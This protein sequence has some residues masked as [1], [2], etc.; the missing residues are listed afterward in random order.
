MVQASWAFAK[1]AVSDQIGRFAGMLGLRVNPPPPTFEQI[2]SRHQ[3]MSKNAQI[4]SEN[5]SPQQPTS[6]SDGPKAIRPRATGDQPALKES[7]QQDIDISS[8]TSPGAELG[9]ELRSSFFRPILAFKKKFAQTWRPAAGYP[10]RGSII[11]SG[12]VEV[13]SPK[14]WL[15]FDVKATYD[16]KE[17]EFDGQNMTVALRRFQV[18][19]QGPMGRA[20]L[21]PFPPPMAGR[22]Y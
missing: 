4:P 15:V 20:P 11:V 13:D 6:I 14:A 16:P 12:L 3:Q 10:P 5:G 17:K 18:K 19:K 8:I 1:V 9:T 7:G 22:P 21:P 2:L